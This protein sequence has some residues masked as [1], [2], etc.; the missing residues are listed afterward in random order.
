MTLDEVKK[1][2]DRSE[3]APVETTDAEAIVALTSSCAQLARLISN[4]IPVLLALAETAPS[5]EHKHAMLSIAAEAG[6]HA[7]LA[8][9]VIAGCLERHTSSEDRDL[10]RA[11]FHGYENLDEIIDEASQAS[12][13]LQLLANAEHAEWRDEIIDT[14]AAEA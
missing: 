9:G 2:L 3:D 11:A 1:I 4:M 10:F 6:L 7:Q 8:R 5:D 13:V 12:T 14:K